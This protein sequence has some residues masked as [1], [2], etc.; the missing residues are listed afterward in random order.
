MLAVVPLSVEDHTA[1]NASFPAALIVALAHVE[2][3][4]AVGLTLPA[5]AAVQPVSVLVHVPD[6]D[7]MFWSSKSLVVF[8]R[9]GL[10][11]HLMTLV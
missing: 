2:V 7:V 6:T 10:S 8:A 5:N 9:V 3:Q 1:L 11:V 4:I